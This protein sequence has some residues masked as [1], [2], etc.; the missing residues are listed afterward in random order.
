LR[1]VADMSCSNRSPKSS[2]TSDLVAQ[3]PRHS[4]N[5]GVVEAPIS[6]KSTT[7]RPKPTAGS[8]FVATD[9]HWGGGTM[10]SHACRTLIGCKAASTHMG[11]RRPVHG[12]EPDGL[13]I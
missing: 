1:D 4:R 13:E 6:Y 11:S 5:E 7:R 12:T 10:A 2:V 9:C 3:R 8:R